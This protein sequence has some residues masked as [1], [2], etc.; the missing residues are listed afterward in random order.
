MTSQKKQQFISQV[1]LASTKLAQ[2]IEECDSLVAV[3]TDRGYAA[4]GADPLTSADTTRAEITPEHIAYFVAFVV[5]LDQ[6]GT[7]IPELLGYSALLN[8]LR[9]DK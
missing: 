3:Y 5:A 6:I 4:E 1:K 2:A 7:T 8:T 9:T